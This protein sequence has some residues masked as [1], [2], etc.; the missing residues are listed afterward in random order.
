[1]AQLLRRQLENYIDTPK[2]TIM[3]ACLQNI[4]AKQDKEA[5]IDLDRRLE[6]LYRARIANDSKLLTSGF[7]HFCSNKH[8]AYGTPGGTMSA[9]GS[10]GHEVLTQAEIAA[11]E[12]EFLDALHHTVI[13]ANFEMLSEAEYID[14][15]NGE[16]ALNLTLEPKENELDQ[17]LLKRFFAR[18]LQ[19]DDP[20]TASAASVNKHVLVYHRGIGTE[21][22]SGFFVLEKLDFISKRL[23]EKLS[24]FL[25]FFMGF[26]MLWK[27]FQSNNDSASDSRSPSPNQR[28][29]S[30]PTANT[31]EIS[32]TSLEN[33]L[34]HNFWGALFAKNDLHE[35]TF[36]EII[37]VYRLFSDLANTKQGTLPHIRIKSFKD[38]PMADFEVILPA[39]KPKRGAFDSLNIILA[40]LISAASIAYQIAELWAEENETQASPE[41]EFAEILEKVYPVLV[42]TATYLAKIIVQL[43]TQQ[44]TY[45]QLIT[46]F[47][48]ER[49]M[50][51]GDG[52]R[53]RLVESTVMQE[54]KEC[55]LAYY[56]L[57]TESLQGV[58][59]MKAKELD[60][61][62]E[63]FLSDLGETLDFEVD[64]ALQKL[65]ND[66]LVTV[67][68]VENQA[69]CIP[70]DAAVARLEAHW[71]EFFVNPD[72]PCPFCPY[73]A[74]V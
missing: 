47:L 4:T 49:A 9:H 35:P 34:R 54:V 43:Q 72:Q 48:Y 15:C 11:Q 50:D 52:V 59:A 58:Q 41:L 29:A 27:L 32:R 30:W 71:N 66:S 22:M 38:I 44:A 20:V 14:A 56:T 42:V 62:V 8:S 7:Q 60:N 53:C 12:D 68:A 19:E 36:K 6:H 18:K 33:L 63:H 64:D 25:A 69:S 65:V 1:M 51:S 5:F 70:I 46:T 13:N 2:D 67:D 37:I 45:T 31:H 28:R 24:S 55:L 40:I 57:W 17:A 3:R 74:H 23:I 61:Y 21:T 26:L 16:F 10:Q 73:T 39:H